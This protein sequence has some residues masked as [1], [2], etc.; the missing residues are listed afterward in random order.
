MPE[1]VIKDII[2]LFEEAA[3]TDR[4]LPS[5]WSKQRVTAWLDYTQEKMYMHSYNKVNFR[6]VPNSRDIQRWQ[7]ATEILKEVVE[8]IEH[9][10]IIWSRAKKIPFT[11]LGR[12]FGMS[13]RKIK[14]VWLEEIIY[15]RLWLQLHE[16]NK[17]IRDMIDKIVHKKRYN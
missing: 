5:A 9:K 11:Q 10:K 17:K 14:I 3:L 15:I 12:M 1:I 4:R 7:I 16:K 2:D 8:S 6:I 13:R